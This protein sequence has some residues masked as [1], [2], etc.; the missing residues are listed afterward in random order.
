MEPGRRR[1]PGQRGTLYCH[2]IL[3][4]I[5]QA[6]KYRR[7]LSILERTNLGYASLL[8]QEKPV[9]FFV[10]GDSLAVWADVY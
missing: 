7:R 10:K 8:L 3:G 5:F 9:D 1:G 2:P 6:N 4:Q